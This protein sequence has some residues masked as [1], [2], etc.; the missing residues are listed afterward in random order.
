MSK[1]LFEVRM[2]VTAF[3]FAEDSETAEDVGRAALKEE[4]D[5]CWDT[6]IDISEV[7]HQDWPYVGG[8]NR[9]SLV[10]GADQEIRLDTALS[11]LPKSAK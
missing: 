2:E 5:N 1:R 4:A 7:T 11:R 6:P 8:W 3:V 9:G 10:Y